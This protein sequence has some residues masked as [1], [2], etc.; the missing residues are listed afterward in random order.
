MAC[1]L[2]TFLTVSMC[3]ILQK[4]QSFFFSLIAC[5]NVLSLERLRSRLA[6]RCTLAL[7]LRYKMFLEL[8]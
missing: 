2:Q 3:D 1:G 8:A 7:S 5:R 6:R 4:T